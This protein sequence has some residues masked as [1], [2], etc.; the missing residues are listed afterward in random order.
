M[1]VVVTFKTQKKRVFEPEVLALSFVEKL[2]GNRDKLGRK[3]KL[4]DIYTTNDLENFL[5]KVLNQAEGDDFTYDYCDLYDLKKATDKIVLKLIKA[6]D[7]KEFPK[8]EA[9]K[10]KL[11]IQKQT[12]ESSY[13]YLYRDDNGIYVLKTTEGPECLIKNLTKLDLLRI[14]SVLDGLKK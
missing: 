10:E 4:Y 6:Q 14:R 13:W 5:K 11:V 8:Q 1:S 9:T 12:A 3:I 2:K 7:E